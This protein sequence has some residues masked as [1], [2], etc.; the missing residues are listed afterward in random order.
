MG[1]ERLLPG[2]VQLEGVA[3]EVA[4]ALVD[5]LGFSCGTR[6]LLETRLSPKWPM[7]MLTHQLYHVLVPARLG[8]VNIAA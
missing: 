5:L 6:D 1:D 8:R 3:Q 7:E 4:E 2:E